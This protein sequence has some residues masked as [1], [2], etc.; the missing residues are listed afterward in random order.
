MREDA[1]R[2]GYPLHPELIQTLKEKT[3]TLIL[4]QR[5]RGMLRL[6]ARTVA[7]LW[8]ERPSDAFAVH[9][10]HI[11]PSAQAIRQEKYFVLH[12]PRQTGKTSSSS[13]KS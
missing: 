12:A 3:A 10:H 11:D 13:T 6:L 4:F 8:A 9:L 2:D 1:F 7:R 5:V